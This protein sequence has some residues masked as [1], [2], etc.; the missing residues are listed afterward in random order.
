[1][2]PYASN[3]M[4]HTVN[5]QD[6][7]LGMGAAGGSDPIVK[8]ILLGKSLDDGIFSWI[9]FAVDLKKKARAHPATVCSADGCKSNPGGLFDFVGFGAPKG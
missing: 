7:L 9:N 5:K 8:Y 3:K 2:Q 4:R 1:M 6:F